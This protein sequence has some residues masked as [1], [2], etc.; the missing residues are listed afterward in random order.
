MID[1]LGKCKKFLAIFSSKEL[2]QRIVF[3]IFSKCPL[4]F[5]VILTERN[6]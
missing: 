1:N 3:S 2:C 4:K 5:F 6:V